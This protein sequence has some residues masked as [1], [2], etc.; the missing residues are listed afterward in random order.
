MQSKTVHR[1]AHTTPE[2]TGATTDVGRPYSSNAHLRGRRLVVARAG[3]AA[4]AGI[5]VGLYILLLPACLLQLQ[6]VCSGPSCA[7]VQP[8]PTSEQMLQKLGFTVGGYAALTV[9]LL[10]L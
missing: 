4:A 7:L 3:W 10:V 1:S 2:L 8:S 6:T 9:S 5:L